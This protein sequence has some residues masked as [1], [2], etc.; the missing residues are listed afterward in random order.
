[1]KKAINNYIN[2]KTERIKP[3]K[4]NW[5]LIDKVEF[6]STVNPRHC[7]Y[8]WTYRCKKCGKANIIEN[9]NSDN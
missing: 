4:H 6:C 9:E 2:A 3:C 5:E 7:W 1:M 8:K